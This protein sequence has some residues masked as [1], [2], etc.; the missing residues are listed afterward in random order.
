MSGGH[1]EVIFA[2]A[3]TDKSGRMIKISP[4]QSL[5]KGKKKALKSFLRLK[6]QPDRI[7]FMRSPS[8]S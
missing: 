5:E 6:P 8:F 1:F 3:Q 7:A 4:K 2:H